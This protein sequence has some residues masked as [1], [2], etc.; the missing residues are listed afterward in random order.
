MKNILT[1][2]TLLLSNIIIAQVQVQYQYDTQNRLKKEIYSNGVEITYTYDQL[3]NITSIT[4]TVTPTTTYDLAF[5]NTPTIG[6]NTVASGAAVTI[7]AVVINN[8]SATVTSSIMTIYWSAD[9][10]LNTG[11]DQL[12]HTQTINSINAGAISNETFNMTVPN[13]LPNGQGYIILNLDDGNAIAESDE[14]NNEGI[15]QMTID[16][17]ATPV[18]DFSANNLNPS[19]TDVVTFSD[20]STN[21]PTSWT[22]SFSPSTITYMNGTNANSQNPQIQF[23]NV[24]DYSATLTATNVGGTDIE[25]KS[26]YITVGAVPVANFSANNLIPTTSDVVSFADLSTN[27][28]TQWT[29]SFSPNTVTFV[30]STTANSQ[31]PQ[32]QFSANGT[33]AVTL[34]ATN[35]Y[36]SDGETKNGYII[37]G[38]NQL[39]TQQI[40]LVQG[41]NLISFYLT[42]TNTGISDVFNSVSPYL[43]EVRNSTTF[44]DVSQLWFLNTLTN[45]QDGQGY[46]V[47]VNQNCTLTVSGTA[48]NRYTLTIPLTTGWN[49]VGFPAAQSET[50]LTALNSISSELLEVRDEQ[51]FYDVSQLPF[52]N[53]LTNLSTGKGYYIKISSNTNLIYNY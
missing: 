14:N 41:W 11:S 4:T 25:T 6:N 49:L 13:G 3:N 26:T 29:W 2:I 19:T 7:N 39:V 45:T 18:A 5:Q 10:V 38:N 12:M 28:P 1:I 9:N 47:K 44:Y 50:V 40:N 21:A 16:N 31:N 34:N 36:G 48:I 24:G 30:N 27:T 35:T 23:N 46:W 20:L 8:G 17:G 33:Y 43:Q 52:L 22:W 15:I 42:P 37:V 53:T 32:V 51:S